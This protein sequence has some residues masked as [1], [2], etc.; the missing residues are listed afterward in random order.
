MAK[1]IFTICI[2]V[3]P[4]QLFKLQQ[5]TSMCKC[6]QVLHCIIM[7][8]S[9]PL[10]SK[11]CIIHYTYTVHILKTVKFTNQINF[12]R[13][14]SEWRCVSLMDWSCWDRI[15][16]LITF[17]VS[18]YHYSA[19]KKRHHPY[20]RSSGSTADFW[21]DRHAGTHAQA[22]SQQC[23]GQWGCKKNRGSLTTDIKKMT[24]QWKSS[25]LIN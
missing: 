9:S 12:V 18:K 2:S 20:S 25:L 23:A 22:T 11:Y 24:T 6:L 17:F 19:R 4:I 16:V 1:N 3:Y 15:S 13:S 14:C 5:S 21:E 8:N 10:H 7:S